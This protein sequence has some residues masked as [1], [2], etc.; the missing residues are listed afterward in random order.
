M[1]P[2]GT[3]AQ[4]QLRPLTPAGVFIWRNNSTGGVE[5]HF[6]PFDRVSHSGPSGPPRGSAI[7]CLRYLWQSYCTSHALPLS[8]CPIMGLFDDSVVESVVPQGSSS[9]SSK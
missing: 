4:A 2:A 6:K 1:L 8:A 9:S 5:A 7:R 3:L